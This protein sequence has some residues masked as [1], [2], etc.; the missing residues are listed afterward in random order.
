LD[1]IADN[2]MSGIYSDHDVDIHYLV[3]SDLHG[4]RE[5]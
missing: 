5:G 3:D 4:S 1:D 2:E